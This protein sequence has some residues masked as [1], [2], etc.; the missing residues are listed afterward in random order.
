MAKPPR[1][2]A[3]QPPARLVRKLDTIGT[4]I[5]VGKVLGSL[6]LLRAMAEQMGL[7]ALVDSLIPMQR[8]VGLTHG[9]VFESCVINRCHAPVPLYE[10]EGWAQGSGM[11][12]LYGCVPELFNDDRIRATLDRL[13]EYEAEIQG[14]LALRLLASEKSFLTPGTDELVPP[15][16]SYWFVSP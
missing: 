16:C 8:E 12:Y 2:R 3:G 7:R 10:M 5:R 15:D 4:R 13:P 14:A 9:Q 1:H 6:V 11:A